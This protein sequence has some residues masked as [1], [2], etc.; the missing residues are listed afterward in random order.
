MP[1]PNGV[2]ARTGHPLAAVVFW[3]LTALCLFLPLFRAGA[4]PLAAIISQLLS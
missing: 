2:S 1:N 4:T 3:L